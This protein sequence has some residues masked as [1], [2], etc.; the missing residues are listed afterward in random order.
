[1]RHLYRAHDRSL[2]IPASSPA[3]LPLD[4]PLTSILLG[5]V[6]DMWAAALPAHPADVLSQMAED[7]AEKTSAGSSAKSHDC[8]LA[9]LAP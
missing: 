5:Y 6:W 8:T 1:M 4:L 2:R 7:V 9:L 3:R